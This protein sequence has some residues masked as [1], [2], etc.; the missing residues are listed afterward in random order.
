MELIIWIKY[1]TR[2][3]WRKL[4]ITVLKYC[5]G[6]EEY[7][8]NS[9][10]EC[11]IHLLTVWLWRCNLIKPPSE[12]FIIRLCLGHWSRSGGEWSGSLSA[13]QPPDAVFH[14]R[15]RSDPDRGAAGQRGKDG[16]RHSPHVLVGGRGKNSNACVC[17][18]WKATT[19]W[20]SRPRTDQQI[21]GGPD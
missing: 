3:E 8:N 12:P 18:R 2:S 21:P 1:W 17:Q 15:N 14:Q 13:G 11:C 6:A 20:S 10:V 5:P 19:S 9:E 4:L 7:P 16:P